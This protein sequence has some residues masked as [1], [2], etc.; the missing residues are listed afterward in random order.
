MPPNTKGL[1]SPKPTFIAAPLQIRTVDPKRL[2][3]IS[4][5]T[6][7]EPFFNNSGKN[8]FDDPNGK[9]KTCYFGLK[10]ITAIGESVLHDARPLNGKFFIDLAVI[11]MYNLYRYSGT[12]LK[13]AV[14]TGTALKRLGGHAQLSGTSFYKTPQKWSAAVHSHLENVDGFIYMSRHINT[15]E[16]AVLFDRAAGKIQA[17]PPMKLVD[18]PQWPR[19]AKDLG[20]CGIWK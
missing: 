17:G 12:P 15:E 6:T 13:L 2:F 7:G 3:R 14:L 9:Y 5:H 11:P 16:T 1:P 4:T 8:R 19:A 20:I 10:L 18:H